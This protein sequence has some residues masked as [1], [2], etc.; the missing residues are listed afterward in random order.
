MNILSI[1][2]KC[3][4]NRSWGWIEINHSMFIHDI[5]DNTVWTTNNFLI[6]PN[7]K[8]TKQFGKILCQRRMSKYYE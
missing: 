4:K 1:K 7:D 8:L 5:D 3:N 6:Y 2:I